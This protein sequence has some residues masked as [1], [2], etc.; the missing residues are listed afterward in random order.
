M[1]ERITVHGIRRSTWADGPFRWWHKCL[2]RQSNFLLRHLGVGWFNLATDNNGHQS[3]SALE[4]ANAVRPEILARSSWWAVMAPRRRFPARTGRSFDLHKKRPGRGT[5]ANFG[6]RDFP[7]I[8][9]PEFSYSYGMVYDTVHHQ[10]VVHLG[11]DL[12][13]ATRGPKTYLMTLGPG[14]TLLAPYSASIPASGGQGTLAITSSIAWTA[15]DSD[16]WIAITSGASGTSNGTVTY[17]ISENPA[18]L[19]A[20]RKHFRRRSDFSASARKPSAPASPLAD[21]T[22]AASSRETSSSLV[23]PHSSQV[24]R[25]A[26]AEMQANPATPRDNIQTEPLTCQTMS[27]CRFRTNRGELNHE[28]LDTFHKTTGC[29]FPLDGRAGIGWR[30]GLLFPAGRSGASGRISHD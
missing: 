26:Y 13:C 4:P 11:D 29:D 7:V 2:F 6:H 24:C 14:E 15:S 25:E 3:F 21:E 30:Y 23:Q 19:C 12:H 5:E 16:S 10:F 8:Y 17:Q 27:G 18:R 20:Q 28:S 22:A 1:A 9:R